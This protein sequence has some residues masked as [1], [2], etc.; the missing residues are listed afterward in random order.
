MKYKDIKEGDILL[1][2]QGVELK[3]LRIFKKN[4]LGGVAYGGRDS[5]SIRFAKER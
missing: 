4:F 5:R 1:N 3:V 2:N